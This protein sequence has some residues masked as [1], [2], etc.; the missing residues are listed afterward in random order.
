MTRFAR[1][2]LCLLLLTAAGF[3]GTSTRA[4]DVWDASFYNGF[5]TAGFRLYEP[6]R[7]PIDF[8]N[9]NY[10]L[11]NAAIFYETNRRR[12][13]N[14]KNPF[15]HAW[16]LEEAAFMHAR[17]MATLDFF[18]HEN[19]SEPAKRTLLQRLALFGVNDGF[20][21]ENISE[22]FGIR[23]IPGSP[24]IPPGKGTTEF[25]DYQTGRPIPN[26]TYLSIAE[27]LLDGW[28]KSPGHRANILNGELLFL[29]C[30]AYHYV[31]HGFYGMDQFK[32]VQ[33]FSSL[34]PGE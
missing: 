11:L 27:A 6:A 3:F 2:T 32:A 20:R 16:A 28:M 1:I 17:D 14:G 4:E 33:N 23:Y 21:A 25:R 7:Q 26:H 30:G 13:E 31:D 8:N 15:T 9:V 22:V 24:V 18:S 29:G 12:V 34:V 19:P 10:P 5:D